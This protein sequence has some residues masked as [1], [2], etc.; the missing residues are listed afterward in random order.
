MA[1]YVYTQELEVGLIKRCIEYDCDLNRVFAAT[2][3]DQ[4]G[5]RTTKDGLRRKAIWLLEQPRT[6]AHF[7]AEDLAI[8]KDQLRVVDERLKRDVVATD[9]AMYDAALAASHAAFAALQA[10]K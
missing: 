6:A 3:P 4:H 9:L 10:S 7:S 2:P 5:T 8:L 1:K